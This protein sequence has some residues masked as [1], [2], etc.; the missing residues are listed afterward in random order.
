MSWDKIWAVNTKRI[1]PIST[2]YT[3]ISKNKTCV[4]H[5]TNFGDEVVTESKPKIKRYV[6]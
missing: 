1:N 2:R 4:V 5:L 6:D 3:S